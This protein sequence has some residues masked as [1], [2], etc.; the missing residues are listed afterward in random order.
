MEDTETTFEERLASIR[1]RV[2]SACERSGRS[3]D[4]VRLLPVAKAFG[5]QAV[6]EAAESGLGAIGENRVQEAGQKIPLCPGHLAW[7]MVGHLQRNKVRDAVRLFDMVHSVDSALLLHVLEETCEVAGKSMPICL[8]VNVSGESSKYG[9][10][11]EEVPALLINDC[12]GL[13]RVEVV[14]LM[15][16][17]PFTPD[18][19]D[20]RLYFKRL[21]EIRDRCRERS[22]F[23]LAELS[24][25][26]TNDFE[27]AVEEGATWIRLG[28][29]LF[30]PRV[31]R[32]RPAP[33]T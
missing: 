22:G 24:M 13:A 25:G 18:A 23:E 31:G 27:V 32:W 28:T 6:I 1:G 2:A 4:E 17:P 30:G 19:E 7:H 11:P 10:A 9:L 16:I 33:V 26:M 12:S 5:P 20:S 21:R 15:T 8:E 3:A 29:G 14:G